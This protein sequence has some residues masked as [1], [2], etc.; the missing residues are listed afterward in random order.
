LLQVKGSG[1]LRIGE[2]EIP[3][4]NR[5]N[6]A[7][8]MAAQYFI[9]LQR[10][11]G[12]FVAGSSI[13]DCPAVS[14]MLLSNPA[15]PTMK[16]VYNRLGFINISNFSVISATPKKTTIRG[17]GVTSAAGTIRSGGFNPLCVETPPAGNSP[18]LNVPMRNVELRVEGLASV[19]FTGTWVYVPIAEA[20]YRYADNSTEI[21]K[22]PFD[23]ATGTF[24]TPTML[25]NA[26]TRTGTTSFD[27]I[28]T[29]GVSRIW[30]YANATVSSLVV[31]DFETDTLTTLPLSTN[32][33]PVQN[34]YRCW[35][36]GKGLFCAYYTSL[37]TLTYVDIDTGIVTTEPKGNSSQ[38]DD[39][40][41]IFTDYKLDGTYIRK[42]YDNSEMG[43]PW[44]STSWFN[45][46]SSGISKQYRFPDSDGWQTIGTF[47][48][49]ST[50][51]IFT[52]R[53]MREPDTSMTIMNIPPQAIA[54]DTPF[55][56]DYTFEV[57]DTR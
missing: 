56:I 15:D 9:D 32:I 47:N 41:V 6:E 20:F 10:L 33:S 37:T 54:I 29:D 46:E 8:V 31:F 11:A 57:T 4:E 51:G 22:L 50:P 39:L 27:S 21:W 18:Y 19:P 5:V 38:P 43:R 3:F 42:P 55:S 2:K 12:N 25:T 40:R 17:A 30:R 35:D 53:F 7:F 36:V 52:M 48:T 45:M 1:I 16:S 13:R 49:T 34:A 44:L 26:F 28:N 23:F 14:F 24:G